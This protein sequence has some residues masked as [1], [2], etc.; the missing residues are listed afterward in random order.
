MDPY[1]SNPDSSP[2]QPLP[3]SRKS[4]QMACEI[5]GLIQKRSPILEF[6]LLQQAMRGNIAIHTCQEMSPEPNG[7]NLSASR[8]LFIIVIIIFLLSFCSDYD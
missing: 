5:C 4:Q 6:R 3:A 7:T 2:T 1:C 8:L